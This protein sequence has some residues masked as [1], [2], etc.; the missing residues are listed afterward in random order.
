M[1]KTY[2]Q[3][4]NNG[5]TIEILNIND[6]QYLV[7]EE[8]GWKYSFY[9]KDNKEKLEISDENRVKLF[10]IERELEKY[11]NEINPFKGK[12]INNHDQIINYEYDINITEHY[13]TKFIR[14]EYEDKD[15]TRGII[16]PD[17]YDGINLVFK[18]KNALTRFINTN[19]IKDNEKTLIKILD[20]S[21]YSVIFYLD[22]I[23]KRKYDIV[24]I[25]QMKG[26]QFYGFNG[27]IVK[28]HP[29]GDK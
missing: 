20:N 28:L 23:E 10:N 21:K 12:F 4:F 14:K 13:I 17:L 22:K 29:S 16:N 1:V 25:S 8:W 18:N 9:S 5:L 6:L 26:M 24:L 11:L 15:G 3:L 2:S 7:N 19:A 27:K